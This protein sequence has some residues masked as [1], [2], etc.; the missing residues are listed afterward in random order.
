MIIL[1]LGSTLKVMVNGPTRTGDGAEQ[2]GIVSSLG[3]RVNKLRF[4]YTSW[5]FE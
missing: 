3:A 1:S 2:D 5:G 4:V